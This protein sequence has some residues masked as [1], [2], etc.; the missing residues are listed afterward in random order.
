MIGQGREM[1]RPRDPEAAIR[2]R[3]LKHLNEDNFALFSQAIVPLAV[4]N[5]ELDLREIFVRYKEEEAG[6]LPPG[7]FLPILQDQ[8]LMPFL[9]RWVVYRLLRWCRDLPGDRARHG[10]R[11]SLNLSID[12]VRHDNAFGDYVL[13]NLEKSGVGAEFLAFE[14]PTAD[15]L[16]YRASM[17]RMIPALRAA[18]CTFALSDFPGD[19]PAFELAAS[20]GIAFAKLD[21]GFAV[22]VDG[23]GKAARLLQITR[24]CREM[25]LR[26]IGTLVE[27]SQTLARMRMLD[28]DYAQ[29][30]GIERPR[31]LYGS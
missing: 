27:D 1:A 7:S 24:R 15:A 23:S 17:A 21:A 11:C 6:L 20:L 9:D 16:V 30:F 29:G 28:V 3:F 25:G 31:P 13:R 10:L 8:G 5:A 2:E 22:N 26:S 14:V 18:G 4:S 19:E 12:T